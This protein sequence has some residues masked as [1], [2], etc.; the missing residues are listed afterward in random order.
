MYGDEGSEDQGTRDL[1][2]LWTEN[3]GENVKLKRLRLRVPMRKSLRARLLEL[4]ADPAFCPRLRTFGGPW[5]YMKEEDIK[6]ALETRWHTIRDMAVA[7][8]MEEEEEED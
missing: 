8:T 3:W 1:L 2:D 6:N 4:V 7:E 5:E